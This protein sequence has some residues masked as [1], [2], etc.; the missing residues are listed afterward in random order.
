ML[1]PF[2]RSLL[3]R[4]GNCDIF[5][6]FF[7][8]FGKFL[9]LL[10]LTREFA[11]GQLLVGVLLSN[12]VTHLEWLETSRET[13]PFCYVPIHVKWLFCNSDSAILFCFT[14]FFFF[15]FVIFL[16]LVLL[17]VNIVWLFFSCIAACK[18]ILLFPNDYKNLPFKFMHQY[19]DVVVFDVGKYYNRSG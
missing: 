9:L 10:L 11:T 1:I 12:Y 16:Y 18:C 5:I 2:S 7:P 19:T 8:R 17:S 6:N 13:E 4:Q 3:F 14:F 15:N